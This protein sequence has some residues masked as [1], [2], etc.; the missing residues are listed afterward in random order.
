MDFDAFLKEA[1]K[2]AK[3]KKLKVKAI[4]TKKRKELLEG[5]VLDDECQSIPQPDESRKVYK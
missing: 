5:I 3:K 2:K 1:E 4:S